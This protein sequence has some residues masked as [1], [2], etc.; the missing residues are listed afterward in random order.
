MGRNGWFISLI[1]MGIIL[2][3]TAGIMYGLI[4]FVG[5]DDAPHV[6]QQVLVTRRPVSWTLEEADTYN[7]SGAAMCFT[8]IPVG[9]DIS[10]EAL[11][12]FLGAE[13]APLALLLTR[14]DVWPRTLFLGLQTLICTDDTGTIRFFSHAGIAGSKPTRD[15]LDALERYY[16]SQVKT[17][18]D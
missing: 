5:I 3:I 6:E 15:G 1:L 18:E 2:A 14:D 4:R 8:A 12:V 17:R 7:R 13:G 9:A 11:I 10:N 16:L